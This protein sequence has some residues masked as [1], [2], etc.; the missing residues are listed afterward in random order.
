MTAMTGPGRTRAVP[1]VEWPT[2]A[3]LGATYALWAAGTVAAAAVWLPLGIALTAIATAQFSSL[4]HEALHGHP[5]RNP[6]LNEALVF[7]ALALTVPFRRFR[8]T[9]LAHHH[10]PVL[11]DPYEDPESNY[12]DPAVWNQLGRPLRWLLSVNNTMAGRIVLGPL[13]GNAR[14]L[15]AEMRLIAQGA[16]GIR[17]AWALHLAG[18]VPVAAWLWWAGMP[19]WAWLLAVWGGHGLLKIRTFLEHRAHPSARA[20]TVIIEDRGPL[21]L[22]FLHNNLHAVHHM[23]PGVAWYR[24][25]A[26]YRAQRDRYLGRNDGYCY[27]GYG[28]VLRRHLWRGKDPVAHP[29]YPW[30]AGVA[31][32]PADPSAPAA[33]HDAPTV[34]ADRAQAPR[35]GPA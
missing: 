5:F 4:Q 31:G 23:H 3:L 8:D 14:F 34:A 30:P 21:A 12:L 17:R 13:I 15:L 25:P 20:R 35:P 2:L 24:L 29:L 28:A 16:P 6:R 33:G 32:T 26:L 22:L 10:D 1:A 7:P 9:H 27:P 11:T 19:V 18:L